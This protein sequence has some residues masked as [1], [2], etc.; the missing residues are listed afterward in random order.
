MV[1]N[2][3]RENLQLVRTGRVFSV[4]FYVQRLERLFDRELA[5]EES[6]S[7][8]SHFMRFL[9]ELHGFPGALLPVEDDVCLCHDGEYNTDVTLFP[10]AV[11][12]NAI[13]PSFR[14]L[15]RPAPRSSA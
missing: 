1:L 7:E 15:S 9:R 13:G 10:R 12:S 4:L 6:E 14:L 11:R 3:F 5:V 8:A 2:M